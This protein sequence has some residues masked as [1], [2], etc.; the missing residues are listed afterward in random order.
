[1]VLYNWLGALKKDYPQG[2]WPLFLCESISRYAFWAIQSLLVLHLIQNLNFSQSTAYE[3]IGAYIALSYAMTFIGGIIGDK[4]IGYSPALIIG[5]ITL[6]VGSILVMA[7]SILYL[8]GF[9]FLIVGVGIIIPNISRYIGALYDQQ[10]SLNR[11][12]GFS[13]FY[14]ASNLGGICGP[15]IA[16]VINSYFGWKPAIISI[17]ILYTSWLLYFLATFGNDL[18][19]INVSF[20]KM[21]STLTLLICLTALL[22]ALMRFQFLVNK[23]LTLSI[24]TAF[25]YVILNLKNEQ[26]KNLS[27]FILIGISLF[28][29]LL[30]FTFEFQILSSLLIFSKD[31]VN[32]NIFGYQIPVTSLVGIEPFC[33]ILAIPL[34][35]KYINQNNMGSNCFSKLLTALFLLGCSFTVFFIATSYFEHTQI[36]LNLAWIVIGIAFMAV[37]EVMLM[38]PLLTLISEKAPS[39]LKSTFFGIL[40]ITI[41]LSGYLAGV[42]AQMTDKISSH[43]NT[44]TGFNET[45]LAV[46]MIC[47]GVSL[48]MFIVK[49]F[50]R[51]II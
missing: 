20:K 11:N 45:Y 15:L 21:I 8:L 10:Q 5:I 34:I 22:F 6:I 46:A 30:F 43:T 25:T 48:I 27:D 38:P 4:L 37:G 40:Y 18:K 33:V 9:S 42:V 44:I 3:F 12:R 7:N 51:I 41:S 23:F 2:Y 19:V 24:L 47:L 29:A 14:L 31:F 36:K 26:S 1:M 39:N 13:I 16:G 49:I 50:F 32:T 28:I 17:I 35:N